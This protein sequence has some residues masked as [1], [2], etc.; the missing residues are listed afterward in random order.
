MASNAVGKKVRKP[1]QLVAEA[2]L[3]AVEE[4][5][6]LIIRHSRS[7]HSVR[8]D[9]DGDV[10]GGGALLYKLLGELVKGFVG[11]F[12][13]VER[14]LVPAVAPPLVGFRFVRDVEVE[15]DYD[16]LASCGMK[17]DCGHSLVGADGCTQDVMATCVFLR[18]C[19]ELLSEL[20]GCALNGGWCDVA[21]SLGWIV[22]DVDR[23]VPDVVLEDHIAQLLRQVHDLERGL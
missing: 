9:L 14:A 17:A 4:R 2:T 5:G 11:R 12:V 19:A 10:L 22:E 13:G 7:V 18:H 23:S 16:R 6:T 20:L 3:N 21:T 8:S 15:M 1:Q